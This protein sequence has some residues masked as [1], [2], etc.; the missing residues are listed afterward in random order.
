MRTIENI[1]ERLL[2]ADAA[3][4]AWLIDSL[5]NSRDRL[6]PSWRWPAQ[7]LD[8][9]LAVGAMGGHGPIRYAV[10]DYVPGARVRYEFKAPRGLV[11]TH[12]FEVLPGDGKGSTLLRHTLTATARGAMVLAWPLIWRPMHDALVEDGL[13]TAQAA[14]ADAPIVARPLSPRVRLLRRLA[15]RRS[16]RAEQTARPT[17]DCDTGSFSS[18]VGEGPG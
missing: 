15:R 1:H 6:W 17:A 8:R 10:V 11:G 2:P 9:P 13:D 5:G 4:V 3:A 12:G 7:V 14:L 18:H 16:C